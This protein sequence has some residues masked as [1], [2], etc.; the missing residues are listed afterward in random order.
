MDNSSP[1][2]GKVNSEMME[3]ENIDS[4]VDFLEEAKGDTTSEVMSEAS[5]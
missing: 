3:I 1:E 2:F 4:D 5:S